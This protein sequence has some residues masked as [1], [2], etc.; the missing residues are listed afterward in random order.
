LDSCTVRAQ[1]TSSSIPS[2]VSAVFER[3]LQSGTYPTRPT[4]NTLK[5]AVT[6]P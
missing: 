6:I 3:V 2:Q 4:A 1:W 5:I